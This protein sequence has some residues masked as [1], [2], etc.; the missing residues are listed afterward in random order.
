MFVMA[1]S[2]RGVT[3]MDNG[4]WTTDDGPSFCYI[5]WLRRCCATYCGFMWRKV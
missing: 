3:R 1:K 5:L 2:Q 4:R